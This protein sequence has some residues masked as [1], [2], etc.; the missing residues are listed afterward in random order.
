MDKTTATYCESNKAT[1]YPITG[2][3]TLRSTSSL[4]TTQHSTDHVQSLRAFYAATLVYACSVARC[5]L[6]CVLVPN[7][8]LFC[9]A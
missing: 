8:S 9:S 7:M 5:R 4:S 1:T 6:K 3:I 2:T